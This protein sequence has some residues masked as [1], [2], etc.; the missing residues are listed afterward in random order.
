MTTVGLRL[1][2]GSAVYALDG[3]FDSGEDTTQTHGAGVMLGL[4]GDVHLGAGG[5]AATLGPAALIT[6]FILMSVAGSN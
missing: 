6:V 4:G 1:R 5:L 3:F 2:D